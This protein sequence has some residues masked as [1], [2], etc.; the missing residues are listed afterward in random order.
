VRSNSGNAQLR[1]NRLIIGVLAASAM[2][3]SLQF[4]LT[5]PA[6]PEFPAALGISG[7]DATWIITITLLTGTVGTPVLSR[8]ADL[9]GRRR[10]LLVSLGLLFLGSIIAAVGMTFTLVLIGRAL[11][12]FA[13]AIVPIGI[14]LI[15]SQVERKQANMGIALMSATVALG[16]ALGLPLSGV[17]LAWGGLSLIFWGSAIA[18]GFFFFA[19]LLIVP[20]APERLDRRLD[21]LGAL[22]LA[23]WLTALL[24][25]VSKAAEW[26]FRSPETLATGAISLTLLGIWIPL[27]L[28]SKSPIIDLRLSAAPRMLRINLATFFVA[29]GMFANHLLTVQEARAPVSTGYGLGLPA[30]SAG[31]V[32]LPFA[33]TMIA[34]APVAGRA[35]NHFG[36]RATLVGGAFIM[37]SGFLFRVFAPHEIVTVIIG[38][39]VLGAGT[40][41]AF[42]AMPALVTEAA[43]LTEVASANGVNSLIRSFSGAIS[44]AALAFLYGALPDPDVAGVL[45]QQG[46]TTAFAAIAG[47]CLIGGLI[48][49]APITR[50]RSA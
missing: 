23:A 48:A 21:V 8:M 14:S 40:S 43:P 41:F 1:R 27:T 32:L 34:L 28:R 44:S 9:Y 18:S 10:M 3:S 20:E 7:G 31:L 49:A 4:T 36:P 25:L 30:V 2:A 16:S 22:L 19:V 13:S 39:I 12:G 11:Q 6:L 47:T 50:Q 45:S 24:L 38:T 15:R 35:L 17:L 5:V 33:L 26:G 37:T 46:I 29:L 42:A